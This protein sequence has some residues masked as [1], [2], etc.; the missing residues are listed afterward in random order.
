M[1]RPTMAGSSPPGYL[2]A[3]RANT[4]RTRNSPSMR[5][6]KI[7]ARLPLARRSSGVI[8][9]AS[10]AGAEEAAERGVVVCGTRKKCK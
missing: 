1:A 6:A 9:K 4:G 2:R 5:K 3:S 8:V 10:W 7:S